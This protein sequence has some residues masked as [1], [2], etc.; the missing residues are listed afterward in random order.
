MS[1][2]FP[3]IISDIHRQILRNCLRFYFLVTVR[4]KT[5]L[6]A[7]LRLKGKR[8]ELESRTHESISDLVCSSA[9]HWVTA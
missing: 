1:S 8:E 5:H 3:L 9:I 6:Q 7:F 4:V 2:T